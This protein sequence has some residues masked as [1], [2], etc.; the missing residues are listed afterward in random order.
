MRR[1]NAR[2]RSPLLRSVIRSILPKKVRHELRLRRDLW[3]T[4]HRLSALRRPV[5]TQAHGLPGALMIN[6]T[7]YPPRFRNLHLTLRSLL[8]QTASAD[9]V[10]L[11]IA[12]EDMKGLPRAVRALTRDNRFLIKATSDCRSYKKLIPALAQYPEAYLVIADDDVFYPPDWLEL[13]ITAW[14]R[15]SE[16]NK[17]TIACHRAH[18]FPKAEAVKN[19]PPYLEWEWDVAQADGEVAGTDL[20]PTGV[21]GVLYPP[22]SLHPDVSDIARFTELAPTGDDLWFYWMARRAA[23]TY[24]KTKTPFEITPW[25]G[26]QDSALVRANASRNGSANDEQIAKLLQHFGYPG[27]AQ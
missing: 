19:F 8:N 4:L 3:R 25:P 21:G 15:H 5:A 16:A 24:V 12:Y 9:Q 26:S 14:L 18:R 1:L 6:V 20:I 2:E 23:S 13:L 11:W 7:S 17:Q 10:I 27:P 22:G